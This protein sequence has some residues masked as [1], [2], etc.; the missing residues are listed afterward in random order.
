MRI[1]IRAA[2]LRRKSG[3]RTF[4]VQ[5]FTRA[6][7]EYAVQHVRKPGQRRWACACPGWFHW[8]SINRR[9][10]KHILMVRAWLA[11]VGGLRRVRAGTVERD[12][13]VAPHLDWEGSP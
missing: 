4:Y 2:A 12:V 1:A 13:P 6:R 8:W 10:C 7:T 9:H 5:S 3:V 11:E